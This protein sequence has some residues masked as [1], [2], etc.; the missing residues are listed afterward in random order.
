MTTTDPDIDEGAGGPTARTPTQWLWALFAVQVFCTAFFV[1][2]AI[3]DIFRLE[4]TGW[5]ADHDVFE[6]VIAGA[7]LL[8]VFGTWRH[9]RAMTARNARL[10]DQVRVASGEF[11]A[12]LEEHFARWGLTPSE[13]DVAVL[14][15]KGLSVAEIAEAR[16]SAEGTVKA[17]SAAVYRKA[18]VTGRMQL[19]TLFLDELMDGPLS[20]LA[21]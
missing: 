18:G 10:N 21:D 2:D 17:H 19:V 14:T 9:I 16:G 13:R 11:A 1:L 4:G 20:A 6:Y 3:V 5:F 12:L 7:L 8:G 15:I